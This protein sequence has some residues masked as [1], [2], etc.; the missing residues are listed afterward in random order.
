MRILF[1]CGFFDNNNAVHVI[2]RAK[3]PIEFSANLFQEKII[4]GFEKEGCDFQV[5]SAPFIGSFPKASK[6]LFFDGFVSVPDKFKYV[7]FN[8]LWGYRNISRAKMLKKE[9]KSIIK[10]NEEM[11]IVIYSAHTPF[12][13]AAKYAKKLNDKVKICLIVLDLPEYMNLRN[14]R[15]K[16]YDVAKKYDTKKMHGLMECVD[17]FVLLTE[18]MREKLPVNSKP[19]IVKEGIVGE[20]Q[21][22]IPENIPEEKRYIVYTGK[23][24]EKF[25]VRDL[26]GAFSHIEEKDVYLVLCGAGDSEEYIHE[27][28]AENQRIIYCGQVTPDVAKEWQ[29]KA[30]VLI[31]PRPNNEEYTKYSFPSKNIEYLLTGKPVVAYMLDG[32]PQFY[33]EFIVAVEKTNEPQ[34]EME[35]AIKK[36]LTEHKKDCSSTK[37]IEYASR[38]LISQQFVRE[39]IRMYYA[40]KGKMSNE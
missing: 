40:D 22:N 33:E 18:K 12:L 23:M 24:D 26:V 20:K 6:K 30:E 9:I 15:S 5:L 38:K 2:E 14:D 4:E 36:A 39:I 8:N 27:K 19:Y 7:K 3:A 16:L 1:L 37:F 29:R 21:L 28:A 13:E 25:G 34:K 10:D 11:L 17:S 32:M 35:R 31:N